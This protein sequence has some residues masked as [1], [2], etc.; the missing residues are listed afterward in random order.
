MNL[1]FH[2]SLVGLCPPGQYHTVVNDV[3]ACSG[4]DIEYYKQE[5]VMPRWAEPRR[6]Y[7]SR[8][9]CDVRPSVFPR[10]FYAMAEKCKV[11]IKR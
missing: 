8:R 3:W 1:C 2:F 10:C 5:L 4:C 7:G 11:C 6:Q 9:V